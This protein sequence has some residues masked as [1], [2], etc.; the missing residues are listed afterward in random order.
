MF[1]NVARQTKCHSF[2][3]TNF[4]NMLLAMMSFSFHSLITASSLLFVMS[5]SKPV[6]FVSMYFTACAASI[7]Y[8]PFSYTKLHDKIALV[9][10]FSGYN[11]NIVNLTVVLLSFFLSPIVTIRNSS[12]IRASLQKS[13][14]YIRIY[15]F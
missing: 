5:S 11:I 14:L 1:I 9:D 8:L 4:K 13:A 10:S 2:Y 12:T 6:L 15:I 7:T 3:F